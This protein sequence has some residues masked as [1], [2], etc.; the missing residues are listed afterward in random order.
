M[1]ST[2][3]RNLLH[4]LTESVHSSRASCSSLL[5]ALRTPAAKRLARALQK[6]SVG[7]RRQVSVSSSRAT[8]THW[9]VR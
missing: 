4:G 9:A 3:C 6:G 1:T 7:A 2:S 8:Q 5:F